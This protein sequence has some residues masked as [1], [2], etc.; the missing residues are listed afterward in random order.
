LRILKFYDVSRRIK[1][2]FASI[3]V[4]NLRERLI[5]TLGNPW[6]RARRQKLADSAAWRV[7]PG[8]IVVHLTLIKKEIHT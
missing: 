6:F 2:S 3:G 7:K 5:A 4:Y 8:V 1:R